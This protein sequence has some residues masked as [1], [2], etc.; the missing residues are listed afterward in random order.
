MTNSRCTAVVRQ[1]DDWQVC[2]SPTDGFLCSK[3]G[4]QL[5]RWIGDLPALLGHLDESVAR[6]TRVDRTPVSYDHPPPDW[7]DEQR[8]I[9]A[10]LRSILGDF[11]LVATPLPV[12][13]DAG[14]LLVEVRN[15]ILGVAR[16]VCEA[17][18]LDINDEIG[19][20]LAADELTAAD[21]QAVAALPRVLA[22]LRA[23]RAVRAS[24]ERELLELKGPCSNPGCR[25]H[26]AHSGPCEVE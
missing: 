18:G 23:D 9:P 5:E 7:A 20:P 26:L 1:G 19:A 4:R 11:A 14:R 12:D 3:C 13:I 17:R 24:R 10:R 22:Q 2:D 16:E 25:L 8:A 15:G 21:R 6:Q